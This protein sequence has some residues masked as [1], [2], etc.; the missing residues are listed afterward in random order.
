MLEKNK[1][2]NI[3]VKPNSS[4]SE[5]KIEND[6]ITVWTKSP[7]DKGKANEEVKK[8]FK[9]KLNTNIE[10]VKGHTSKNKKIVA[11]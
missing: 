4:F 11:L 8:L 6:T 7:P 5:I 3:Y 9:K 2:Y 10:I 1:Y